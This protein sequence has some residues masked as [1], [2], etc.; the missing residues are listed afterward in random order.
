MLKMMKTCIGIIGG[1][2]LDDPSLFT[3]KQEQDACN[4]YGQPSSALR[5]GRIAGVDVVLL[6]RHGKQHTLTPS[7]VNY[8]ANIYALYEAGCTHILASAACG[9]LRENIAPGALVIPDQLIDFTHQRT[10]TFFNEFEPGINNAKHTPMA[11]PFNTFLREQLLDAGR[12]CHLHLVPKGT[13]ITIEGPRFSTRAES[14][15]FRL[16]G[17]DLV[18]MTVATEAILANELHIPYAV[19]AMVTDY[20]SWNDHTPPLEVAELVK[21]FANNVDSLTALL[22]A[23]IPAIGQHH[24][25]SQVQ[26]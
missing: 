17:A 15:M 24:Q 20:D 10:T 8:R 9:S 14:R 21:T 16:W 1:S 13:L 2:G 22:L 5:Y 7:G 3:A 19:A 6:S 25:P 26:G 4:R 12:S 11:E 23:A 18:N